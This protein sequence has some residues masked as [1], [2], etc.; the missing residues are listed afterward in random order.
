MKFINSTDDTPVFALHVFKGRLT[1]R[2][3]EIK[4]IL[5]NN[6][7]ADKKVVIGKHLCT[8]YYDA[9]PREIYNRYCK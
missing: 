5:Q 3:K 1:K 8:S 9:W 4:K 2:D 6:H 7:A